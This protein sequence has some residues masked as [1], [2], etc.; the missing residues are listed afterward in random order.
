[1]KSY[2]YWRSY[3][4]CCLSHLKSRVRKSLCNLQTL[5]SRSDL[6]A[7]DIGLLPSFPDAIL[8]TILPFCILNTDFST[9]WITSNTLWHQRMAKPHWQDPLARTDQGHCQ[10]DYTTV[11]ERAAYGSAQTHFSYSWWTRHSLLHCNRR[12]EIGNLFYSLSTTNTPSHI[13]LICPHVRG[14]LALSSYRQR[15]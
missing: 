2:L 12:W 15:D 8:N 7:S 11:D 1:M 14:R 5:K 4:V 9:F 10:K 13:P 6:I 3:E